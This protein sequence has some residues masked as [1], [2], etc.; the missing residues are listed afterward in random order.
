[1]LLGFS[2]G[3]SIL[4]I[5]IS[6]CSLFSFHFSKFG[7]SSIQ[8][9]SKWSIE[10]D[11]F[12]LSYFSTRFLNFWFSSYWSI[13][14]IALP[15]LGAF[16]ALDSLYYSSSSSFSYLGMFL[17]SPSNFVPNFLAKSFAIFP[18][19]FLSCWFGLEKF[20]SSEAT[21]SWGL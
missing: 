9:S 14:K 5:K 3:W 1:M 4:F 7:I 20:L 15:I 18:I 16:R 21:S 19:S 8:R 11:S 12:E 13:V 10:S 17:N 6:S 2:Q